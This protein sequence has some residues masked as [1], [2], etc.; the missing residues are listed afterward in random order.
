MLFR[1]VLL[2]IA[3]AKGIDM[4]ISEAVA[5]ILDGRIDIDTAIHGLLARP[6]K[7]EG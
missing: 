3:R 2:D 5:A 7:A 1:S 4:P 6:F